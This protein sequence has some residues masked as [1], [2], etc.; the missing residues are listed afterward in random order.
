[1]DQTVDVT[2]WVT[3]IVFVVVN[4]FMAWTVIRFRNRKAR[5]TRR[6][7]SRRTRSSNGG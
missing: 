5:A 4:L 1:M 2:F 7:T 6:T 3:G